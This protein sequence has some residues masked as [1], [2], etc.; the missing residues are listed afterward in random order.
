MLNKKVLFVGLLG[1]MAMN[2]FGADVLTGHV[3]TDGYDGWRLSIQMWSFNRF[4]LF[5]GIDKAAA[6]GVNY[7]EMYPGQK[8]SKE[9][10]DENTHY[11]MSIEMRKKIQA[12]LKESGIKVVNYG[13]VGLPGK[14]KEC[15]KVFRF[16]KAMGIETIL[17][18]PKDE[19]LDMIDELA[20]EYKVKVAIH[21]HPKPTKYWDPEIVLGAL[22]GRSKWMGAAVDIGHWMRSGLDPVESLKKLEG[23][24]LTVHFKDLNEFG[25]K[26]AH[27]MPWGTGAG[28]AKAVLGEF[29]R[30]GYKGVFSAEYEYNWANNLPEIR[31]CAV[32]FNKI[33]SELNPSGWNNIFENDLSNAYTKGKWTLEDGV[34]TRGGGGDIGTKKKYGD[35]VL[36]CGYKVEKG[37]NSGIFIRM[38]SRNWI[39]WIEVQVEDSFGEEITRH[40]AGGVFD[41]YAPKVNAVKAPGVWNRCT[42]MAKDNMV[43]VVLNGEVVTEMDLDDW[44]T[45]GKNPDGIKNKFK[46]AY[47]DLPREGFIAFQDHGQA[48]EFRNIRIKELK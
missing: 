47:K 48:I 17:S 25:V 29:H 18:E 4:T 10:G 22:E 11:N 27:D 37:S 7:I 20:Q 9:T 35:F 5:E 40:T 36:D 38:G 15:R 44:D 46:I 2:G 26:K 39:P 28:N 43:S 19:S 8:I 6:A 41:V 23:K 3:A 42:V 30:Q 31:K 24:I 33:G 32:F 16:A 21:N 13:V 45:A 1:M 14:E 12:K 34:L